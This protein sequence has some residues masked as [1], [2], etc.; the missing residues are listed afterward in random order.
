VHVSHVLA[1]MNAPN[2]TTAAAVARRAGVIPD[3]PAQRRG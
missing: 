1:K 3:L 2:R